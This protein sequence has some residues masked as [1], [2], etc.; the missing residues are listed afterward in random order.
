MVAPIQVGHYKEGPGYVNWRPR[1][2]EDYLLML[3]LSGTGRIRWGDTGEVRTASGDVI[4]LRPHTPH[5]YG[6][7][8]VPGGGIW[9]LAW[10]HFLPRPHWRDWLAWPEPGPGVGLIS[11]GETG[12]AREQTEA[13]LLRMVERARGGQARRADFALNE[14]E[15][16]LLWLDTVNPETARSRLDPRVSRAIEFLLQNLQRPISVADAA[17]AAGL[18]TS[19]LAHLFKEQTGETPRDF[20]E[21]ERIRRASELLTL[22]GRSVTAIAE[23]VGFESPFYFTQRFKKR[24]GLSPREWRRRAEAGGR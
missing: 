8:P 5:D 19:R 7:A 15:T 4:L 10:A 12:E 14:L 6:T 20:I 17:K 22:T 2:T 23:E 24:T 16:A 18:S 21:A 9:E 13:A 3:T 1:G 11:V